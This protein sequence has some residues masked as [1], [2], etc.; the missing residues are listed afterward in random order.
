[1]KIV[2]I[3]GGLGNQM[4]QYA[5]ALS[6]KEEFPQEDILI[7]VSCFNGYPLHNGFEI[8]N[9]F[10]NSLREASRSDIASVNYPLPHYRLWQIGRRILPKKKTVIRESSDMVFQ[11]EVLTKAGNI[12]YDGYWQSEKYFNNHR[13]VILDAFKFPDLNEI[14]RNLISSLNSRK[15]CSIH[16]R[17]GDYLNHRLFKNLTD[18][19]YYE[20][21]VEYIANHTDIDYFIVFSND[22]E[23]CKQN[24]APLIK[25]SK[26]VFVDWNLGVDSYR[27]MQLMSLCNHNIVANSSFSW[28]GAWLNDNPGKIVFCPHKWINVDY[29]T[30]IIPDSWIKL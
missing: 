20:K 16:V 9:I 18:L 8:H 14:N 28:W 3:L 4:F 21:A 11:P 7:D 27:D 1:M 26:I 12:Y 22:I 5:L 10:R 19:D 23:W 24:I 29:K 25:D 15:T 17:R 2:N 13:R 6:L 30:D